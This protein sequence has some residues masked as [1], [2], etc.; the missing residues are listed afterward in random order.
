M[1]KPFSKKD[2]SLIKQA[3]MAAEK[4]NLSTSHDKS[5]IDNTNWY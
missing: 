3:K 4:I 1:L 5:A 2:I